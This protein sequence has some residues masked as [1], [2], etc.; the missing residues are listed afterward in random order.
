MIRG[1]ESPIFYRSVENVESSAQTEILDS[2]IMAVVVEDEDDIREMIGIWLE[3]EEVVVLGQFGSRKEFFESAGIIQDD[4][5]GE[6]SQD[7]NK[8]K[9][10]GNKPELVVTDLGIKGEGDTVGCDVTRAAKKIF[11]SYTVVESGN[12]EVRG[13]TR[14]KQKEMGIDEFVQKPFDPSK[15]ASDAVVHVKQAR[16]Q[17]SQ[18]AS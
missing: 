16:N 5:T 11:G 15:L 8:S 18:K 4:I 13:Y 9:L 7:P 10:N 12:G 2:P 3:S 17:K 14:E 6:Y 1:V